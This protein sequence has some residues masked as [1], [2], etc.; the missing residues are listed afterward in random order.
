[1]STLSTEDLKPRPKRRALQVG[2]LALVI[3]SFQTL[4]TVILFSLLHSMTHIT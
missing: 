4:G 3:L 2:G 1:M